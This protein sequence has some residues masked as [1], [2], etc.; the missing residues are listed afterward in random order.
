[1][2]RLKS[3]LVVLATIWVLEA[4]L[5]LPLM[6]IHGA[7]GQA[8]AGAFVFAGIVAVL[9]VGAPVVVAEF[10]RRQSP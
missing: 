9:I 1:M 4:L 8:L 7:S 5:V 6:A 3:A 2:T 10:R